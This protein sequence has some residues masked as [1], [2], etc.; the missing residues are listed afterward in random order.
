[1]PL[2][3]WCVLTMAIGAQTFSYGHA[4]ITPPTWLEWADGGG[5]AGWIIID[6]YRLAHLYRSSRQRR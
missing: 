2:L 3:G 6:V 1:M 4:N 5:L